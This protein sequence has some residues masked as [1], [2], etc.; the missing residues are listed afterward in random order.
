MQRPFLSSLF[1]VGALSCSSTSNG[2][3]PTTST[4][5]PTPTDVP[6]W[7]SNAKILACG[8]SNAEQDCRTGICQHN[9]NVDTMAWRG[10]IYLVHRTALSQV[11]GPNS[12]LHVYR[13]TDGGVTFT[14]LATIPAPIA[15]LGSDDKATAGRDLRDPCFY[16][17]GDRLMIKALT[18]LPVTS[19]RDSNVDTIA[20]NVATTDGVHWS[21]MKEMG[22]VGWSFWRIK[23][24]GGVYYT[25]AYE[26]GDKSVVLF[27]STDG[28]T[29]TK[30]ATVWDVAADTPLETELQEMPSGRMLALVRMDGTNDELFGNQGRLRTKVCWSMPP[31]DK[32]DCPAEIDGQRLDGPITFTWKNRLFIVARRHLQPTNKKRT[33]LFEITGTLDGGP[34]DVRAIGDLPSA[35]DTSYAG[36]A[37]IDDHRFV[38]SWYSGDIV[39]DV[40]WVQGMLGLSDVWTAT[41]DSNKL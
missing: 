28:L 15:P 27:S 20:I 2:N 8:H 7:L 6:A 35:G 11:L 29:W 14:D 38:V 33:T 4:C 9:E 37:P 21:A 22:P 13:S 12:A 19:A 36:V 30:G 34:I 40:D 5:G 18:R 26:D 41:I 31:Y 10:A 16:V 3:A 39:D 24:I 32:F 17:V 23:Q 1:F 25:A